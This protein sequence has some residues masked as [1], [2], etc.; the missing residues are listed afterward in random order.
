MLAYLISKAMLSIAR[1]N[2]IFAFTLLI[3]IGIYAA[4]TQ[5]LA[6]LSSNKRGYSS[7][8]TRLLGSASVRKGRC[9]GYSQYYILCPIRGPCVIAFHMCITG[10]SGDLP[11]AAQFLADWMYA[12]DVSPAQRR[13]LTRLELV[14]LRDR[15]GSPSVLSPAGKAALLRNLQQQQQQKKTTTN[16]VSKN[17]RGRS[18]LSLSG[19]GIY[20]S[21]LFVVEEDGE[22]LG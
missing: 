22:L 21:A 18:S 20:P 6:C 4:R 11:N 8:C 15:Y 19:S 17:Q 2:D 5:G 3:I 13:E 10:N 12:S 1:G 16:S 9:G 14:D 7:A